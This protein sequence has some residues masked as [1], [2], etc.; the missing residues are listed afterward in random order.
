MGVLMDLFSDFTG[1]L[2]LFILAFMFVMM[3]FLVNMFIKKM[4]NQE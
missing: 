1:W 3:G 4:N 2:V